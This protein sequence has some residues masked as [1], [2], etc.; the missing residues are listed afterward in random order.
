MLSAGDAG[1]YPFVFQRVPEPVG[2]IAT[3]PEQPVD[4]WQVAE[5]SPRADVI[6]DLAG[7]DEQ[8]ERPPLAIADGMQF[9][10]HAALGPTDQAT[11]PPFFAAM[12]V[13]VRCAFK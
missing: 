8:V 7:G 6:A 10:V 1:L 4:F 2:V 11:T 5:Q 9:G 12:L 3:I 13:A